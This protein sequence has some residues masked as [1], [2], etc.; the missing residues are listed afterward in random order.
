MV[1]RCKVCKAQLPY[2]R[3]RRS[4]LEK[5]ILQRNKR[6]YICLDCGEVNFRH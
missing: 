4:M 6:K 5:F 1:H 3:E 2:L